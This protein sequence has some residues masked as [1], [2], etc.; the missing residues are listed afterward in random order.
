MVRALPNRNGVAIQTMFTFDRDAAGKQLDELS[1]ARTDRSEQVRE[2]VANAF[3]G[4]KAI[5]E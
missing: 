2:G 5:F 1:E 3:A 4:L